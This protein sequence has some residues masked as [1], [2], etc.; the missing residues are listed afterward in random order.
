MSLKKR[1]AAVALI[2]L[3]ISSL[4]GICASADMGPKPSVNIE[5]P[6]TD[7]TFYVTLLSK[8]ASTGPY[9]HDGLEYHRERYE[10]TDSET[11]EA[12]DRFAAYNDSDGF[13]FLGYLE[14]CNSESDFGWGY[15]PPYTFKILVYYPDTDSFAV[16]ESMDRYAFN[17]YYTADITDGEIM[18]EKKYDYLTEILE[19]LARIVITLLVEIVIA[20]PFGLFYGK[21]RKV[22]VITN[23]VT[24]VLLNLTLNIISYSGGWMLEMFA[25]AMLEIAVFVIE[26]IV[27]T[28]MFKKYATDL[29][30]APR[31]W[32]TWLYALAANAASLGIGML[33]LKAFI[34]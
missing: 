10:D 4:M 29:Q 32:K 34:N 12:F 6:N 9:S 33:L 14:R 25:Y 16:S 17:S 22:I 30:P 20:L 5:F 26:G 24:Q 19:M 28:L 11:L 27:Y 2:M 21:R 15:Y 18:T 7:R 3:M 23:L 31:A 1:I 8:N 13:Y